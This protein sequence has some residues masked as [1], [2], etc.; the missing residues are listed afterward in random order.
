MARVLLQKP[1]LPVCISA[2][3]HVATSAPERAP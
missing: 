1:S 3:Q 2:A